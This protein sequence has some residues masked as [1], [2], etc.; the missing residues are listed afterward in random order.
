LGHTS[1]QD[2]AFLEP[3]K[4]TV[5]FETYWRF[6]AERQAIFFRRLA[7]RPAPWTDDP[8][9]QQHKFTN[10]YRASDRVS[11]YLIRHVIYEGDPEPEEVFFRTLLF[12]LFNRIETWNTLK[13]TVGEIRYRTYAFS[14]YDSALSSAVESGERIYSPAYIMPSGGRIGQSQRKHQMHLKLLERMMANGLPRQ[15]QR[16]RSMEEVF[17]MLRAYPTI[18][19]FL[20]YQY[21]TDLNYS[22]LTNFDEMEFVVPGPG[23]KDG[24][25]KCF[26]DLGGTSASDTIRAVTER[27]DKCFATLAINFTSLWGRPLQLIDCQNLFCEVGKYARVKHPE[28]VGITKRA[29]VKQRFRPKPEI[30]CYWYPPKW[31]LNQL[32]E[33][34]VPG[35]S[36]L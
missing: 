1:S 32:I 22:P 27:Q 23:A 15:I 20:A 14:A 8:I 17:G 18:G 21:A 35:V 33:E 4:P 5:V 19:D 31:N 6:A 10:A 9:L 11:Q 25:R 16:A 36:G 2:F 26:S 28:F 12:K 7:G 3:L 30:V 34:G 13:E 29:R 24:I